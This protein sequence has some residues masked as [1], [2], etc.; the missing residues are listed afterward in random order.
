MVMVPRLLL[1]TS[2]LKGGPLG[3]VPI[4]VTRLKVKSGRVS[5]AML[6]RLV[7][8]GVRSL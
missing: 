2:M 6:A 4:C 1:R 8:I 5:T 3:D 7:I